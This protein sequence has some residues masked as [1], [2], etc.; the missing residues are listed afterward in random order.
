MEMSNNKEALRHRPPPAV[1][2]CREIRRKYDATSA[3]NMQIPPLYLLATSE[4]SLQISTALEIL[5][6]E[7]SWTIY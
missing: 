6:N 4:K 1:A 5:K 3:G 2:D 7:P